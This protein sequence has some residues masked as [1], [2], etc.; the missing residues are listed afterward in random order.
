MSTRSW[1]CGQ[2]WELKASKNEM[3]TALTNH[4]VKH[5]Y[6]MATEQ[7]FNSQ[8]NSQVTLA[9]TLAGNFSPKKIS[10]CQFL[11]FY[12]SLLFSCTLTEECFLPFKKIYS[13][14]M[15]RGKT[16]SVEANVGDQHGC[17]SGSFFLFTHNMTGMEKRTLHFQGV[18]NELCIGKWGNITI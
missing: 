18:Y 1:H 7:L 5:V 6:S 10:I 11:C 4:F 8:T 9:I 13:V 15:L 12:H 16:A 17:R 14:L 2:P 3:G